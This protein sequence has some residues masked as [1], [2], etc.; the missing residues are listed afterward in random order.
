VL[1]EAQLRKLRLVLANHANR[2]VM[3]KIAS[4]RP[5]VWPGQ[6][7][8]I[9]IPSENGA[10]IILYKYATKTLLEVVDGTTGL[11]NISSETQTSITIKRSTHSITMRIPIHHPDFVS[12]NEHET[13]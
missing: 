7:I 3:G 6:E 2:E 11:K 8:R 5:I 4:S 1:W 10:I 12:K 9:G 13:I